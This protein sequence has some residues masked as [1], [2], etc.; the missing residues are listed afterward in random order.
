M[1]NL[2]EKILKEARIVP[3]PRSK[4]IIEKIIL[5]HF[6]DGAP[7]DLVFTDRP[8]FNEGIEKANFY[9]KEYIMQKITE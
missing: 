2:V 6:F 7:K 8:D 1:S 3:L 5:F 4:Q 9:W